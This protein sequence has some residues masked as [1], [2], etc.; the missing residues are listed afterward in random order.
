M[1]EVGVVSETETEGDKDPAE[2]CSMH[3][4]LRVLVFSFHLVIG[5]IEWFN[6]IEIESR[7]YFCLRLQQ[8]TRTTAEQAIGRRVGI[9]GKIISFIP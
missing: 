4:R 6:L 1:I 7:C 9:G 3:K 5:C 2:W 8:Q